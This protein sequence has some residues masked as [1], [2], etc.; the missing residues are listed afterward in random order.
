[1]EVS[2]A[3]EHD[4]PAVPAGRSPTAC[5][6]G[7]VSRIGEPGPV[8]AAAQLKEAAAERWRHPLDPSRRHCS[9]QSG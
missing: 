4:E 5:T 2:D 3:I 6:A 7:P 9:Y 1:M 8:S